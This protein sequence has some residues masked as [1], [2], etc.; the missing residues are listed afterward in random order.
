MEKS[1]SEEDEL[2]YEPLV[3][4]YLDDLG[5][6]ARD[7]MHDE[8]LKRLSRPSCR[9]VL[10]IGEP[11]AGKTGFMATFARHHPDW[12]RYFVRLDS[13]KPLSD[14]DAT[15][16]LLRLGHQLAH[17]R[18]E[19]FDPELLEIEVTQRVEKAGSGASVVG[20]KIEDLKV[21]PF[22]RTAIRVQQNVVGLAGGL[23]GVE[24]SRATIEPRLLERDTLSNLA[25]FDPALVLA[26]KEPDKTIVVLIDALDEL[27]GKS[28]GNTILDWLETIAE[29]A[30]N[31]RF[32]L[33]SRPSDRLRTLESVRGASLEVINIEAESSQVT[34]DVRL[35]ATTLFNETQALVKAPEITPEV[36]VTSLAKAAQGNFAYLTAYGRALRAAV[37]ADSKEQLEELLEFESLPSGLSQL[38]AAFARRI[39][40]Q[41]ETLGS[42]DIASPR[43]PNDEVTP[44]WEGVGQRLLSVLAVA[45][46]PLSLKQLMA[47]GGIRV[48]ESAANNVL[49]TLRPFLDLS[50]SGW[51]L[52]HSSLGE[53]LTSKAAD[54]AVDVAIAAPEWHAR[55]IRYYRGGSGSWADVDW[56]K[57]DSYGLVHV[58]DHVA[59]SDDDPFAVTQLVTA[60]LREASKERFLSD[61]PFRH[62]VQT[63][64]HNVI[65]AGT[66]ADVLSE[67]VFLQ[68]GLIGLGLSAS[69]LAPAVYG[70]MARLGRVDEALA[71]A[72][73]LEP[74]L[75]KFRTLEAIVKSTPAELR[76]KLGPLDGVERLVGAAIEVPVTAGPLVGF[77]GYDLGTCLHD[78]AE[79]MVP[80]DFARAL[81]L[82]E[83]ADKHERAAKAI[84]DVYCAAAD[85]ASPE[86]AL[87]LLSQMQSRRLECAIAAAEKAPAGATRDALI[88]F[89]TAHLDDESS[90]DRLPLLARLLVVSSTDNSGSAAEN[91]TKLRSMIE[92]AFSPKSG[93]DESSISAWSVP[94]V[95]EIVHD[96]DA[97]L[98]EKILTSCDRET[99]PL[100]STLVAAA[101]VWSKWGRP[102]E[103]RQRLN[104]AVEICRNLNWYGPARDLAEAARVA[105]SFDQQ[106][107]ENLADEAVA[108][109]EPEVQRDDP[110]ERDRLDGILSGMVQHFRE[111]DFERALKIARWSKGDWIHGGSW[112]STDG[113]GGIAVLGL[114]LAD[115]DPSR[116]AEL[117]AECLAN[118]EEDVQLGRPDPKLVHRG[119]FLP[120]D[121][122][123]S[124]TPGTMQV[125]SAA[126]YATNSVN[127]WVNG[128]KWR[129]FNSPADVLR[130]VDSVFPATASWARAVAV[131]VQTVAKIDLERAMS[132]A[133][134]P[135]DPCERLLALAALPRMLADTDPRLSATLSAIRATQ[136]DL[137]VY[138]P[139]ID[140]SSAPQGP[141]LA[142]L[143]PTLRA[144][145][146]AALLCP[147][148]VD[149][150]LILPLNNEKTWYLH[151][152]FTANNNYEAL[153]GGA[154][155][156]LDPDELEQQVNNASQEY[157]QG[158]TLIRDLFEVAA[159]YALG[160]HDLARADKRIEHIEEPS[161]K[162]LARLVCL[163]CK[164]PANDSLSAEVLQ[165]LGGL[166]DEISPLHRAVLAT[167]GILVCE[168]ANQKADGI[169]D[170]GLAQLE[171]SDPLMWARGV[172]ALAT[173]APEARR[174]DL[175]RQAIHASDQIG[176]QYVRSDAVA[177]MLSVA[178]ET[179]NTELI[180]SCLDR[181]LDGGFSIF[182]DGLQRAMPSIIGKG[183]VEIIERMDAAMRRA[184]RLLTTSTASAKTLDHFDGVLAEAE[185]NKAAAQIEAAGSEISVYLST[186][187]DQKDMGPSMPW[188]QDSRIHRP[189]QGDDAFARLHGSHTGLSCWQTNV[190]ATIFRVVDIRFLFNNAQDAAAYHK[191]RLQ[192]NSEGHPP[193]PG[194]PQ[195]GEECHVFGGTNSL[196]HRGM[197]ITLTGFYY[198]F[199]VGRMVVKLFAM[200]GVE[201]T[202]P[203]TPEDLVPLAKRIVERIQTAGFA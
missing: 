191:E 9:F 107:G 140:L 162:A 196:E 173:V 63:A 125:A 82:A 156:N 37:A 152:V 100:A 43:G 168:A 47:L 99:E 70:L 86:K 122:A 106:W 181:L 40:R 123:S 67:G 21:S 171:S 148:S 119:L 3:S 113:R 90:Y 60:N 142:Y 166:S 200:Q 131:A 50:D 13:T 38:Y 118:A 7:W 12:L 41:I 124:S 26:R 109:V 132:M 69:E 136:S 134:W 97:T 81:Q 79:A 54:E 88:T 193:V 23:T 104:R 199:R 2:F 120:V 73:V 159:A 48:W 62:I 128:R 155:S 17:R 167:K 129:S 25:L 101:R 158:D 55:I 34:R 51:K 46:A 20:V 157:G 36:A 201:A 153:L 147:P 138:E 169:L 75:R 56:R 91:A 44:A 198:V 80:H 197:K 77:L 15:S 71:R 116:A 33:S 108:L 89:A 170:W 154:F 190:R 165:I 194:A 22:Y 16:M 10:L 163:Q 96:A 28:G 53:F 180:N 179:E 31:I 72:D 65:S 98:A 117:L 35:F 177:D 1:W 59:A 114:D 11:G 202:R 164:E 8:I 66:V 93:E 49:Q 83:L 183:G 184:Q 68:L 87:E 137:P 203:L 126:T 58:A 151:L 5:T 78:A 27:I 4:A 105:A 143:D 195:V 102:D 19:I 144:R 133:L 92:E 127:Y 111:E 145:F 185:R 150:Y 6:V 24:I 115:S 149:P 178:I 121:E 139:E 76:S 74:G 187:L 135:A 172:S 95:A 189:D 186:Y 112:D 14:G 146:E 29:P 110:H 18:P 42:L 161:L 39:R 141:V 192:A 84:D 32:V 45:F 61:L 57:V 52:F 94:R 174:V 103:A 188:V 160:L 85:L 130:S 182:M 64:Q 30:P 176:N 175:L